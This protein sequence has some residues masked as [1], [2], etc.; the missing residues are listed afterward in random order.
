MKTGFHAGRTAGALG[1]MIHLPWMLL[2]LA[3]DADLSGARVERVPIHLVPTGNAVV[4]DY[5]G[6]A[7]SATRNGCRAALVEGSDFDGFSVRVDGRLGPRF[8][9]IAESTPVFSEDGSSVAYCARRADGWRWVVNGVEGPVHPAMTA[10][11]FAFSPN[12]R[13]HAYVVR[14]TLK[15]HNQ[16]Q[17]IVD[18]VRAPTD[19]AGETQPVDVAPVFSPD[20]ARLAYAESRSR[21]EWRTMRVNLDGEGG[22]WHELG[23][24][25]NRSPGFGRLMTRP[26]SP[27]SSMAFGR[28]ATP[29]IAAMGFSPDGRHFRY[30]AE[31]DTGAVL[32]VD[33][34]QAATHKAMGFDFVFAPGRNPVD[35]AYL[36]YDGSRH[37]VA[38][39]RSSPL[40]IDVMADWTLT[41]SPDGRHL[42]F[43]GTRSGTRAIWVDGVAAPCDQVIQD[44]GNHGSIR[45]SPDSKRLAF[46]IQSR[47]QVHWVVDGKAGPG[48]SATGM[49][50]DFSADSAHFAYAIVQ[51]DS[52]V[53]AVVVDGHIRATHGAVV[54]GPV[55]RRDGTLEY[56]AKD[57]GGLFRYRVTGY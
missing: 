20:G 46:A 31:T 3:G 24:A 32:V 35:Y 27:A 47:R 4:P 56:L 33:G 16:T 9:E 34:V 23:L 7:L 57:T 37:F 14:P 15:F 53:M 10:T 21:L 44:F 6:A 22:R 1:W 48:T 45:Y 5:L 18:G 25:F 17:L 13:R 52:K 49:S 54:T 26:G 38:Q 12:G 42:A 43:A 29:L 2:G 36:A 30:S 8:E 28:Q 50:F 19:A 11:S 40:A 41:Y 51:D 55:F 39:A